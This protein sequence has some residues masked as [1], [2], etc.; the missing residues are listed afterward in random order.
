M[1]Y[2]VVA[3]F[4]YV[5]SIGAVFSIYAGLYYWL[6]KIVGRTYNEDLACA[7][8]WALFI[9]VNITFMPQHFL[10]LQGEINPET[11]TL[12]M[13]VPHLAF[14]G[15]LREPQWLRT[16][17]VAFDN[18][19]V[20]RVELIN[21]VRGISIIY[22]WVNLISGRTYIGSSHN[23]AT[24]LNSYWFPS[25]LANNRPLERSLAKYNHGIFAVAILE[26]VG[27]SD[28]VLLL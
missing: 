12:Y 1:T 4:H 23:G 14:K 24:R 16:P 28:N 18:A 7:H 8:F 5:L 10:G 9:G 26:I 17:V 22:Q 3:H 25:V 13:S 27:F 21:F 6:P 11:I 20:A 19:E 15:P 2:Y